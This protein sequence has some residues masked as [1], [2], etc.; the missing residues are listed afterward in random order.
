MRVFYAV[1]TAVVMPVFFLLTMATAAYLTLVVTVRGETEHVDHVIRFWAIA[2]LR[3]NGITY[4]VHEA[5]HP[6]PARP[7]IYVSNHRSNADIPVHFL[8]VPG[9]LRYLAKK[10][11]FGIPVFGTAIRKIGIVEIDRKAG[12]AFIGAIDSAMERAMARGHSI[13]VYPE[14][15][16]SSGPELKPFKKGA[17]H[18]AVAHELDVVPV[19]IVGTSEIWPPHTRVISSGHVE[20]TIH[21]PIPTAGLDAS[22]VAKLTEHARDIIKDTFLARRQS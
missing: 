21:D 6:D 20:V 5:F 15:T 11:L 8:A 17:F 1:R 16:R 4:E 22:D 3:L 2:F 7:V 14:G 10:E 9:D 18:I 13:M 19:T 12:A